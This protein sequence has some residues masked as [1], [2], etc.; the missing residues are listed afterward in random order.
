VYDPCRAARRAASGFVRRIGCTGPLLP[1]ATSG[2]VWLAVAVAGAGVWART[3]LKTLS[4]TPG[5]PLTLDCA[6]AL[7]PQ[8]KTNRSA[9]PASRSHLPVRL[10]MPSSRL[11]MTSFSRTGE[12]P[13]SRKSGSVPRRFRSRLEAPGGRTQGPSFRDSLARWFRLLLTMHP[14]ALAAGCPLPD[15]S[16]RFRTA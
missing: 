7:E 15:R 9:A 3:S 5:L 2:L 10:G 11:C 4:A 6:P 14:Q 12:G 1:G 13:G 8:Y 16:V